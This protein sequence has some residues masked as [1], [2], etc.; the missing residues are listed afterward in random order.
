MAV[1]PPLRAGAAAAVLGGLA[2]HVVPAGT[3]LPGVRR[4]L[5]PALAGLG[6][7]PHVALT[8]DDGPDPAST[9]P[10]LDALDRLGVRATF[11]VLGEHVAAHRRLVRETAARGHEVGLHGWSHRRPWLPGDP[12]ELGELRRA[13]AAVEAATGVPVRWYRPPYGILTGGRWAA[14]VRCGLR[15]VLWSAWGR[16]WTRDATADSVLRTLRP[17]LGPGATV[18]LHD[19]DRVA[20]P[21]CWLATLAA[22]PL[23][24]DA[25]RAAGLVLGP[26]RDHGVAARG[27]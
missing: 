24:D 15:P 23:L 17:D 16:D 20:A 11:F 1:P 9:P 14:A 19:S 18:L 5:F 22:L 7:G 26:L 12:R 27:R 6:T 3:W 25:C 21:G 2:A 4:A 8:F 10:F 13:R